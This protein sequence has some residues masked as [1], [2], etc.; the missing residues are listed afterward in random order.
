[1]NNKTKIIL[2]ILCAV[3]LG[4][5]QT[6]GIQVS[7]MFM[8]YDADSTANMIMGYAWE[9][10][11]WAEAEAA[12]PV[13][14]MGEMFMITPGDG[15][16]ETID[17]TFGELSAG[18]YYVGVFETT[19]MGYNTAIAT[20]GYYDDTDE[21]NYLG[22]TP[23]AI[24][25]TADTVAL[26]T[27]MAMGSALDMIG[28]INVSVMFMNYNADPSAAM[29]MAY[30]W[31]GA[32]WEEAEAAGP[33]SEAN[34]GMFM[35]APGTGMM[36][37]FDVTLDALAAGNYYVGVFETTGMMHNTAIATVGYYNDADEN[38]ID[39]MTPTT[40]TVTADTVVLE[41]MMAMSMMVIDD[42]F[43]IPGKFTLYS[44][45]N[46]FNP[47]TT[48]H[49]ALPSNG[50]ITVSVFNMLGQKVSTLLNGYREAGRFAVAWHSINDSGE[51]VPSGIYFVIMEHSGGILTQKIALIK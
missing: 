3:T 14:S 24:S 48:I 42:E 39:M 18:N 11:T 28:G 23:S 20:L 8:N 32:T 6:G 27:M 37:T 36:G 7:V 35:V 40:I 46:P 26:Q 1:M 30:A 41:T 49:Y 33:V 13:D 19:E 22:Y 4:M 51:S 9:G 29:I 43:L 50:L 15:M 12:G 38:Y 34:D 16:M 17:V 10:A 31:E 25:V 5:A 47:S 44:Y 45:P 21:M 2:S